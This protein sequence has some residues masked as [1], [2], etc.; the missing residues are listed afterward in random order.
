MRSVR[1]TEYGGPEVLALDDAAAEPVPGE[2]E[3]LVEVT[4]AGVTFAD[5]MFRRGQIPVGLPFA[6]GL[7]AVG[8]VRA[9]GSAVTGV[10][11]GQR[12]AA[13]CLGGGAL[14][15]RVV[16]KAGLTVPLEGALAGLGS[17]AAAGMITNGVT[18]WGLVHAAARI[19]AGDTVLVLAAAGGVGTA[20]AQLAK[21]AGA[22]LVIGAVGT[23]EKAARLTDPAYDAVTT[24]AA[25][26][27]EVE[28]HTGERGVDHA[29]DSVGGEPRTAVDKL[30]APFGRHVIYG[31]AAQQDTQYPGNHV[32]F[33]NSALVGYNLGDVAGRDPALL[34]GHLE[35][36][37]RALAEGRLRGEP[38]TVAPEEI[39]KVHTELES[40]ASTGKYVVAW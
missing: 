32:W 13:L 27:A 6:P 9:T 12:V 10:R 23:P 14:S 30:L 5:V 2:D 17:A 19:G 29:F 18:A 21:A 24:Y 3:L 22:R 20:V 33:T 16:A 36:A 25:L 40:R 11:A 26:A 38:A 7:E 4:H 35:S 34:R 8:T 39:A 15:E 1:F 31:D 28:R 37:L